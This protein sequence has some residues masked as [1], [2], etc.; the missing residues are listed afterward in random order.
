MIYVIYFGCLLVL[1]SF[2]NWFSMKFLII[3]L[4]VCVHA[5]YV[6]VCMHLYVTHMR[7]VYDQR[8][9]RHHLDTVTQLDWQTVLHPVYA[10]RRVSTNHVTGNDDALSECYRL[11]L[12]WNQHTRG[13]CKNENM[14]YCSCYRI[15]NGHIT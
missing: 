7:R 5:L 10:G 3:L 9:V 11:S 1:L 13:H 15:S 6:S 12:T 8:P 4:Y 2:Q 14:I